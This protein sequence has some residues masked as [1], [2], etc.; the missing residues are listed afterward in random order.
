MGWSVLRQRVKVNH[1]K[2]VARLDLQS[3]RDR[4]Q[5]PQ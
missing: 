5:C 4:E 2:K 1:G 3:L